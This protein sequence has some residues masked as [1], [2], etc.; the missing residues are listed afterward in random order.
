[1]A[2]LSIALQYYIHL[3]LNNDPGWEKIKVTK[4]LQFFVVPLCFRSCAVEMAY[5]SLSMNAIVF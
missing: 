1:M 2:V 5:L 4:E 3:R